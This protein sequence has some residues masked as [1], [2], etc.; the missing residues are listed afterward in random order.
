MNTLV[1]GCNQAPTIPVASFA[2]VGNRR[3]R[4]QGSDNGAGT[5]SLA[6]YTLCDQPFEQSAHAVQ[7]GDSYLD[8]GEFA[9]SQH[10]CL[11][12]ALTVF[13]PQ[14]AGDLIQR[15][16]ELLR[17]FDEPHPR[18]RRLGVTPVPAKGLGRL[19]Y[20]AP[21][22][23]VANGLD[24][25]AGRLSEAAYGQFLVQCHPLDSVP[26]YGVHATLP[27]GIVEESQWL[28]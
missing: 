10:A 19:V 23:V 5:G 16:A 9:F 22:L 4:R 20:E 11:P 13:Q 1:C 18:R 24:V 3:V 15:E 6:G 7:V 28:H 25:H 14:Q 12:T 2:P 21:S 26:R 27:D 8:N 17:A